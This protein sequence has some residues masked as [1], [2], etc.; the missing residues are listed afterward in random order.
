MKNNRLPL[1]LVFVLVVLAI[2]SYMTNPP[3]PPDPG[4]F[5]KFPDWRSTSE[6]GT[7]VAQAVNPSG[8]MWAGAWNHKSE[9][10]PERSAVHIIDF[11]GY[12]A[13]SCV[14]PKGVKIDYLSWADDST[15]RACCADSGN[16]KGPRIVLIDATTGKPKSSTYLGAQVTRVVYW[17]NNAPLFVAETPSKVD[18]GLLAAF[19]AAGASG[20]EPCKMIGKPVPFG[21]PPGVSLYTDA[22][23]ALD[24]SRFIFSETDPN[25][26][27][28]RSYYLADTRTGAAKKA[29]DLHYVPGRIEGMWPSTAGV[30]MVCR[31]SDKLKD[32]IKFEDV[33]LD[34]ATGKFT[35]Q[36]GGVGDLRKWPG[37][38]KSMSYT[39]VDGGFSLDLATGK[40]K[41]LFDLSKKDQY[42]DC[43]VY[44][45]TSGNFVVVS[46]SGGAIDIR[47]LKPDGTRYR[48]LLPKQ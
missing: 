2:I 32:V 4:P 22:G 12:A 34:P 9:G 43:R 25:A 20:K 10:K 36:P 21:G 8:T 26:E 11:N 45:L 16:L 24:G 1:Y 33:I 15:V 3:Q 7:M 27:G 39:I 40:V 31:I 35:E 38:P 6:I 23:V 44:R 48:D 42:N 13:K 17:P 30:L 5:G 47:E 37:A 28:G 29:F 18:Q 19:S 41:K 46:E 14:L